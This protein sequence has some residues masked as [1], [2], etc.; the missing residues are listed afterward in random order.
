MKRFGMV[1]VALAAVAAGKAETDY[2][3]V[4][5]LI[6][7][8]AAYIFDDVTRRLTGTM[9]TAGID[10]FIDTKWFKN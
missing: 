8:G 7:G 5:L 1:V 10:Y 4:N 6:R 2:T 9:F 3:P